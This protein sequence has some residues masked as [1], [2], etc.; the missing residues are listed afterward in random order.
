MKDSKFKKGDRVKLLPGGWG[1]HAKF[2]NGEYGVIF[3]PNTQIVSENWHYPD[4]LKTPTVKLDT[5][6]CRECYGMLKVSEKL[7]ELVK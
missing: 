3:N 4:P 7:L 5:R 2:H 6:E 1:E